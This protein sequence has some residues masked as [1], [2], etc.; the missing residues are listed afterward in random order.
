[1]WNPT[2][3]TMPQLYYLFNFLVTVSDITLILHELSDGVQT[4]N[5]GWV[6]GWLVTLFT[7]RRTS[8]LSFPIAPRP[9]NWK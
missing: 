4:R 1:V 6:G 5:G 3:M 8:L 9:S 7:Q 2:K